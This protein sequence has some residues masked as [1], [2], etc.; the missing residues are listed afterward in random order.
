MSGKLPSQREQLL[1]MYSLPLVL[2]QSVYCAFFSFN[3]LTKSNYVLLAAAT[4]MPT[5]SSC[6][7]ERVCVLRCLVVFVVVTD[8]S[9]KSERLAVRSNCIL[10]HRSLFCSHIVRNINTFHH[11][12]YALLYMTKHVCHYLLTLLCTCCGTC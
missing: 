12:W 6:E 9:C 1:H 2:D 7:W 10:D 11:F 3:M 4:V 5:S 8:A